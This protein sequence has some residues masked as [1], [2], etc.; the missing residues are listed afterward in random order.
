[1]IDLVRLRDAGAIARL[2]RQQLVE[3]AVHVRIATQTSHLCGLRDYFSL[4]QNT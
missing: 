1:V 3:Q 2:P 4:A